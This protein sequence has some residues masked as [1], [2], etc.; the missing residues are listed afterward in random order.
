MNQQEA[1]EAAKV[2]PWAKWVAMD[3]NGS[4]IAYA[5]KPRWDTYQYLAVGNSNWVR[6]G[7]NEREK[8]PIAKVTP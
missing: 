3:A 2:L 1:I 8:G 6:L 5:R 7:R 4:W